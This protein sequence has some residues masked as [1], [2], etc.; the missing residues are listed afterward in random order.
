MFSKP[1]Y[2]LTDTKPYLTFEPQKSYGP[3]S[4]SKSVADLAQELRSLTPQSKTH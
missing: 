4:N 2:P 1:L 3:E